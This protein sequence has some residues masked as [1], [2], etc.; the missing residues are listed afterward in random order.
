MRK[1]LFILITKIL[2]TDLLPIQY[3]LI[4]ILLDLS[5]KFICEDVKYYNEIQ[6]RNDF[7]RKLLLKLDQS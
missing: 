6:F 1:I 7:I 2:F 3:L 4:S 5:K